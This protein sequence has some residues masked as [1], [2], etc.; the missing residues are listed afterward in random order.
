LG[1][2]DNV[3]FNENNV[4]QYE[5]IGYQVDLTGIGNRTLKLRLVVDCSPDFSFN[6]SDRY[7]DESIL[8]KNNLRTI[9]YK[10]SLAVTEFVL[11]QN[12]PNPF[13]PTTVISWQSPVGGHQTLFMIYLEM[14]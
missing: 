12:Y 5:N 9:N 14:R 4:I 10:G 3:T 1:V 6:L 7:A 8:A 2:F 11:E 13:N